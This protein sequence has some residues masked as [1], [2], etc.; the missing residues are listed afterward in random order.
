M[1]KLSLI[2]TGIYIVVATWLAI[3]TVMEWQ[4][5][6]EYH[7]R[8]NLEASGSEEQ[9]EFLKD[10]AKLIEYADTLGYKLTAG[11]LYRTM[12]QQ[13]RYVRDGLSWT[14]KSYHLERK[15]GDLNLFVYDKLTYKKSD[16]QIL[17]EYWESLDPHNR[18]GGRF[19]DAQHFERRN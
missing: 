15:A 9:W 4:Q 16:Y 13:R 3:P 1:K 7:P 8:L 6:Y 18:W 5:D 12:Y 10:Y 17:G 11:E 19:N 2:M 14:Y